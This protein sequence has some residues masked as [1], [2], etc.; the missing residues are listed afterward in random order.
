[1]GEWQP[2]LSH[3]HSTESD[4]HSCQELYDTVKKD[5]NSIVMDVGEKHPLIISEHDGVYKLADGSTVYRTLYLTLEYVK[6]HL[7]ELKACP[8]EACQTTVA[9]YRLNK[10]AL[11][12]EEIEVPKNW[13][14]EVEH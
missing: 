6:K 3:F 9:A 7:R 5:P 10:K 4:M 8:C 1:M 12:A 11:R 13:V 2:L 14:Q